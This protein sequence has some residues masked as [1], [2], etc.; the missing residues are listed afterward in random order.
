[1]IYIC[2]LIAF[3]LW[4]YMTHYDDWA[5]ILTTKKTHVDSAN[6]QCNNTN[7]WTTKQYEQIILFPRSSD[8][9]EY[10]NV[11][12]FHH[13][14]VERWWIPMLIL[15]GH[16]YGYSFTLLHNIIFTTNHKVI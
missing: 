15:G 10:V 4:Y 3:M 12:V 16:I 8:N 6:C 14:Y 2:V 9:Y 5:V 13:E 7:D 11:S 1:M